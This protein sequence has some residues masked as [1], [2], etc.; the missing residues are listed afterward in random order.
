M[1]KRKMS[2]LLKIVSILR[3]RSM[4]RQPGGGAIPPSISNF[5]FGVPGRPSGSEDDGRWLT[6][7]LSKIET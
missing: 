5:I 6:T 7:P 4:I 1:N 3:C 2:V